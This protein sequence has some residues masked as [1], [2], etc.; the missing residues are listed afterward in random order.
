MRRNPVLWVLATYFLASVAIAAAQPSDKISR[1]GVLGFDGVASKPFIEAFRRGLTELGHVEGQNIVI[2][3]RWAEARPDRLPKLAAE[4][5]S[6]KVDVIFAAAAPVI[7]A[8]KEATQTTPIVFEMLADPVSAGFVNS[9]AKPGGNLTGVAGLAPEL[10]GKRLELLKEIVPRLGSI[11]LLG[12]PGNPNFQ[13][14]LKESQ[15]AAAILKLRLQVLEVEKPAKLTEAFAT[16]VKGGAE[17]LAVFPDPMLLG[18]QKTIVGLAAKNRLPAV[19]G[20]SGVVENGGLMTYAPSQTEMWH[21][22]ATYIDK[23]LK[24]A[25]PAD[26]PVEQPT[27]FEFVVNLKAAKQIGLTIPPNVL[28]RADRVIK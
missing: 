19:Y 21:R 8:A 2:E 11:A 14:I 17:A 24:G 1:V 5:V 23:I 28:A 15:R 10:G 26:L 4:M 16:M 9:L 12:N 20:I 7:R 22:A 3:Y 13:S 25:K 6:L 27:K 18:A